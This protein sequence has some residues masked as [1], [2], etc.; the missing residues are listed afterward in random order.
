MLFRSGRLSEVGL[1]YG[2]W[3]RGDPFGRFQKESGKYGGG[4]NRGGRGSVT[5][6]GLE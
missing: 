3:L 2:A 5:G 6:G 4:E 1:Q